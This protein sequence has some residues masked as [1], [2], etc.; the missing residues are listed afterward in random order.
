MP[1]KYQK[2]PYE[3]PVFRVGDRV[4]VGGSESLVEATVIEDRGQL[5]VGGRRLYRIR[6]DPDEFGN[7]FESELGVAELRAVTN[8]EKM[9]S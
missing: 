1:V 4:Y 8:G 9:E 6:Y 7:A 3:K 5:G 2:P